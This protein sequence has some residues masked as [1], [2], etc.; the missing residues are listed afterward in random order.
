M[1]R[2]RFYWVL[3]K[4]TLKKN[5][6]RKKKMIFKKLTIKHCLMCLYFKNIYFPI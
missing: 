2:K 3:R 4:V 1:P 5:V 6:K